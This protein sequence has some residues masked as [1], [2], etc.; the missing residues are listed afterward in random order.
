MLIRDMVHITRGDDEL[1]DALIFTVALDAN[2]APVNRDPQLQVVYGGARISA[3]DELRRPV[4]INAVAKSLRLPFE[5]VR[6]RFQRMAR[7]GL[8]VISPQ[9]VIIPREAVT[10]AGYIAKQGARYTRAREFY[11]ALKAA[12][13]AP[14]ERLGEAPPP[15]G[16][17]LVRAANRAL[18]EYVLRA[19]D[20]LVALTGDMMR[21]L[22]L[23]ELAVANMRALATAEL[24][25]WAFA[26]EKAAR[27]VRI[28][29]LAAPLRLSGE[30][31]RR[32]LQALE[33]QGFCQR[34]TGGLVATAPPAAWPALIG[35][36]V[37]NEA[38]LQ[39]LLSRLRP[40]GVLADWDGGRAVPQ[41]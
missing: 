27:P 41:P 29:A 12:G 30:T 3:P 15:G 32:H 40:L 33:A 13:A 23:L 24:E 8:C 26:P 5:T 1:R 37:A 7:D 36:I 6:R 10:S 22:V 14:S 31:I 16:E 21:S 25:A 17:P 35:L 2:M 34:T 19:C 38:N 20:G 9:G 11:L 4:S 39:R 28:A 18:S